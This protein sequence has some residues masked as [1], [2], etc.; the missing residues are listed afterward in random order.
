MGGLLGL[1]RDQLKPRRF[2]RSLGD[3]VVLGTVMARASVARR[4]GFLRSAGGREP[5]RPAPLEPMERAFARPPQRRYVVGQKYE[6]ERQHPEA[7]NRQDGEAAADDQQYAG[8]NARPTGGGLSEPAGCRLDAPGK[9][10]EEPPQSPLMIDADGIVRRD[11][12][13]LK[14]GARAGR[15]NR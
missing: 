4:L 3:K 14:I 6:A 12:R 11:S 10:A 2:H 8:R 13:V 1:M 5:A 9:L 7:E 15:R